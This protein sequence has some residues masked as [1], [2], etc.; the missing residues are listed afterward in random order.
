MAE[1]LIVY[2]GTYTRGENGG[3][4][5]YR[6]DLETGSL[7]SIG[8][9]TDIVNPSFLSLSPEKKNLYAVNEVQSFSG[10]KSG[11]VTSFR[12]DQK[13]GKLTPLNSKP[14]MGTSPCYIT[15]DGTGKYAIVSNYSSGSVCVLPIMR[16]GSLG[17]PVEVVQH[18]GSSVNP[19]RQEAPHPHSAVLDPSNRYLY[20][21]DLGID[22]IMVYRF[23]SENGK[24][25]PND[26][27]WVNT[28]PGAGPRHFTFHP[29]GKFA[30]VINELDSTVIAFSYDRE[31]GRLEPLQTVSTLPEGY[32]GTN[33]PADI[34]CSPSG[35]FLYGSNRGH[36]SI[37][38][39]RIDERTGKLSLVGHESTRGSFPRNFAIDPTGRYLL[40]ANQKS[41]N[42][43]V[44]RINSETGTLKPTGEEINVPTPA[45]IKFL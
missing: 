7:E 43:I 12:I 21:P 17:D 42:L 38:I 35:K 26:Q 32:K 23:D 20:V 22:K 14:S 18:E 45:C 4:Y 2:V 44:F 30:Y 40:V 39:Y 34:H 15:V 25:T 33:Y 31:S 36:D 13:T 16:D 5:I 10:E 29:N 11:A 3:I 1:S 9:V 8:K 41:D 28:Q 27:P 19:K 6:I 24:L 37:V